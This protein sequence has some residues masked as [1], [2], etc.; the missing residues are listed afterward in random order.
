MYGSYDDL[1]LFHYTVPPETTRAT[2]EFASFQVDFCYIAQLLHTY[3]YD[4]LCP[5]VSTHVFK[6]VLFHY[7]MPP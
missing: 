1:A 6:L 5:Y 4:T 2:W 3:I 7:T